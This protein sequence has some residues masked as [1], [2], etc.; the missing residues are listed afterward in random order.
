MK[1]RPLGELI[2]RLAFGSSGAESRLTGTHQS[3]GRENQRSSCRIHGKT[4]SVSPSA[5]YETFDGS[6]HR[7]AATH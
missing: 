3:M 2:G 5:L 4:R 1:A 6:D 7:V